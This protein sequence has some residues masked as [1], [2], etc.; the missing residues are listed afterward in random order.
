MIPVEFKKLYS[1]VD[2]PVLGMGTWGMGG[3]WTKETDHDREEIAA[4]KA[5][6]K[7]GL[8]HIDTAEMYGQG[9]TEELVGKAINGFPRK[10]LFITTKV[11]MDNLAHDD[12]I[13]SAK[14]SLKKLGT[15]YVDLYLL[16]GPNQNIPIKETME[17]MDYLVK[18]R[19]TRFIGVSN[20]SVN[21]LRLAQSLARFR[22]A[23]NQIEYNLLV[24]D[25]GNV[26]DRMESQ[27]IPYCQ[28]NG[29]MVVAWRPLGKG[30]IARHG[31][32]ALDE[33]AQKYKKTQ[34]QIALN[35]LISKPGIVTIPK[36]SSMEHM[37]ENL[38]AMGWTLEKE[39]MRKLDG[40]KS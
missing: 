29:I 18:K 33:L 3:S 28:A 17:A 31:I 30:S 26:T 35:W 13:S 19:M 37:R 10:G 24:R 22:I 4:L 1:G 5:G 12:L 9:H 16:H 11:W 8:T 21:Q 39:D 36:A 2:I 25:K 14:R 23:V 7:L 6:I 40:L 27:I 32:K 15:P 20:F 38:G 34:A